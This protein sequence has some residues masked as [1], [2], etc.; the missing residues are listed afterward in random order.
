MPGLTPRATKASTNVPA[1]ASRHSP[2]ACRD[3]GAFVYHEPDTRASRICAIGES[4]VAAG[5]EGC[6]FAR[7]AAPLATPAPRGYA[8]ASVTKTRVPR[9]TKAFK[10]S[11]DSRKGKAV[12]ST[13]QKP[14]GQSPRADISTGPL[15]A[16]CALMASSGARFF[17]TALPFAITALPLASPHPVWAYIVAAQ[18]MPVASRQEY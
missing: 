18:N 1:C 13:V 5:L 2:A 14:S 4:A 17:R 8:R 12:F 6:A 11:V 10:P 16:D 15:L 3:S 7:V 9:D